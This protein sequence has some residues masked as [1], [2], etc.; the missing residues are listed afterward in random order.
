MVGTEIAE[1]LHVE[2]STYFLE[3]SNVNSMHN[4]CN[5]VALTN[6]KVAVMYSE[7]SG[8]FPDQHCSC[9]NKVINYSLLF[10]KRR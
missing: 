3:V 9:H 10:D 4:P 8:M 1:R 7:A 5:H 2:S 6:C